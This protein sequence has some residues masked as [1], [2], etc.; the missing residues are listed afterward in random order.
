MTWLTSSAS[1]AL[2]AALLW[3]FG[4]FS[5]GMGVKGAGGTIAAALRIIL[6]S[7]FAS[8]CGLLLLLWFRGDVIPHGR[9]VLWGLAAGVTGGLSLTAFYVALSRG[10]MGAS[11]A[12]S[13]LLAAALPA[14]VSS[15]LEG[16]PGLAADACG[17]LVTLASVSH[18]RWTG[19]AHITSRSA[20]WALAIALG[21][22]T[23]NLLF[24]AATRAGRLDTASV[25]AS[26]YPASTILLAGALLKERP[27]ARQGWGMAVAALAVIMI[28]V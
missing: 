19:H 11:A 23:G 8:L 22:T 25:L 12:V 3:G 27:T 2:A 20:A 16:T 7:H 6:L 21:D 10:A 9:P 26:L 1:L 24:I 13:G 28:T 14:T 18:T 5:G 15:F 17:L 4:D